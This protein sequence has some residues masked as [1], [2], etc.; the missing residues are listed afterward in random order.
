MFPGIMNKINESNNYKCVLCETGEGDKHGLQCSEIKKFY[1]NEELEA[2][3]NWFDGLGV[4]NEDA[5]NYIT[6]LLKSTPS[7]DLD[8]N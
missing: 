3:L 7:D 1:T 4:S 5:K 8:I 6:F 2:D